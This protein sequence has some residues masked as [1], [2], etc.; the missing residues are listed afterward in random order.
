MDGE[1]VHAVLIKDVAHC[2]D[3]LSDQVNDRASLKSGRKVTQHSL[4][5][6]TEH[7]SNIEVLKRF[8]EDLIN[9]FCLFMFCSF[10]SV[11][12]FARR[13]KTM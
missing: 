3:M 12:P 4:L 11:C 5:F 1:K 8:E 2:A 9:S 13:L 6:R 10:F 7:K